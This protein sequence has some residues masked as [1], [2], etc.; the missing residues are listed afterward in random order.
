MITHKI[1]NRSSENLF[2]FLL[3]KRVFVRYNKS[4]ESSE[5]IFYKKFKHRN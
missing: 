5:Q 4:N 1:A 3:D 2:A